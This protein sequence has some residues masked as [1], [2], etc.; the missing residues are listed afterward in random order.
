[1]EAPT[2]TLL[3]SF[4]DLPGYGRVV[5]AISVGSPNHLHYTYDTDFGNI[6]QVWRGDFLDATP[7]WYGRGDG[8]ARPTGSVLRFGKPALAVARLPSTEALWPTDTV[9][10]G[11][12]FKGYNLNGDELPTYQFW[13]GSSVV[14]DLIRV[15][16]GGQEIHRELSIDKPQPNLYSRL[17]ID[18]SITPL[19]NGIYVVGD[20]AYYL[21]INESAGAKPMLRTTAVGQEL[22]LPIQKKISYSLFY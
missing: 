5:H 22:L 16:D 15:A 12:R 7:M 4:V 10:S 18:K 9:G 21:R 14:S 3:R 13:L 8:S 1:M 20:Q 17:A 11:Y 6:V 19:P 2:T